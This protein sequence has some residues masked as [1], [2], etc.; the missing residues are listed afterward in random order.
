MSLDRNIRVY[1][2]M[3]YD[4][5]KLESQCRCAVIDILNGIYV[6][7]SAYVMTFTILTVGLGKSINLLFEYWYPY[8]PST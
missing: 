4:Y 5:S 3:P 8:S 1:P 2:L 6:V 7:S